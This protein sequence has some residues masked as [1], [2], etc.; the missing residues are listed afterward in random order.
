[1]T[2]FDAHV[3]EVTWRNKIK[4]KFARFHEFVVSDSWSATYLLFT[5]HYC[6]TVDASGIRFSVMVWIHTSMP[7]LV[8]L[9]DYVTGHDLSLA[10]I[11]DRAVHIAHLASSLH[12]HTNNF[13]IW[14]S[15]GAT[16]VMH[17]WTKCLLLSTLARSW[18]GTP[19]I[20]DGCRRARLFEVLLCW[21]FI[22]LTRFLHGNFLFLIIF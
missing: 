3:P 9:M 1:M 14:V 10:P 13:P 4:A 8:P 17:I 12:V 5:R 21:R 22:N 18:L 11:F 19:R 16:D 15:L 2:T 6:M 20:S 7:I